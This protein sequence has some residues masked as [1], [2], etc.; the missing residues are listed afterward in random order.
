MSEEAAKNKP[1]KPLNAYFKFR[2]NTL[3]DLD[4]QDDK[5]EKVKKLWEEIDPKL[6]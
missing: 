1:K 4:G 2:A 3:K 6:K 5:M